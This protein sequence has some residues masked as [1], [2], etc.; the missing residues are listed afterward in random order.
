[1]TQSVGILETIIVNQSRIIELLE[2]MQGGAAA[3]ASTTKSTGGKSTGGKGKA[4]TAP[5]TKF[6]Q[7][8][9][10]DLIVGVKDTFGGAAA[11]EILQKSG[12]AKLADIKP[13]KFDELHANATAKM[14]EKEDEQP[15]D[16]DI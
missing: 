9:V 2:G 1:M 10:A 4:D 7:Q 5:V 6:T 11:K 15:S 12:F 16:D 14:A 8:E 13:E 3:P